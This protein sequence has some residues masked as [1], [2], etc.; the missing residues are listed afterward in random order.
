MITVNLMS[1]VSPH[2][3]RCG[4]CGELGHMR[5]I[6]PTVPYKGESLDARRKRQS[7][8]TRQYKLAYWARNRDQQRAEGKRNYEKHAEQRISGVRAY[9]ERN[10]DKV[11][12]WSTKYWAENRERVSEEKKIIRAQAYQEDPKG[13]WLKE[14][15]RAAQTRARKKGLPFDK[16]I[17]ALFLPDI[18]PVLGIKL[19]YGRLTGTPSPTSPSLDRICPELGY[20]ASNLRV[21]SNR[22]NTL[23]NNATLEEIRAL[24]RDMEKLICA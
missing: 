17:P 8:E 22:A 19:V 11:K 12:I 16:E 2:S 4:A 18:C 6:C 21:I 1:N 10:P 24:V 23:K 5:T 9:Q 14:T 7:D 13:T 20:V 15:F 3:K